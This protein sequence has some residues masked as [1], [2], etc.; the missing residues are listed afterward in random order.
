[1]PIN[2]NTIRDP[3]YKYS[4]EVVK[5]FMNATPVLPF[6]LIWFCKSE[7][8]KSFITKTVA[9]NKIENMAEK[10]LRVAQRDLLPL[11]FEKS[12]GNKILSN[13]LLNRENFTL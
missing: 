7:T 9:D 13:Y 2:F 1:M 3:A 11:A 5:N 8:G 6:L 12:T 10:M 4:K